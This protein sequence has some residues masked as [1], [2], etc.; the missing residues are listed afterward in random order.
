MRRGFFSSG[1]TPRVETRLYFLRE[2]GA[3]KYD[4]PLIKFG[5]FPLG[6][7]NSGGI[8]TAPRLYIPGNS[9]TGRQRK[10]ADL[11]GTAVSVEWFQPGRGT[12]HAFLG[13]TADL[14][15]VRLGVTRVAVTRAGLGGG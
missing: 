4:R 9:L 14:R 6:G 13:K 15:T 8:Q 11:R 3:G 5:L 7:K 2:Y 12:R 1:N 10:T